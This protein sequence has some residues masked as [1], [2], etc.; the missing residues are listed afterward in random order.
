MSLDNLGEQLVLRRNKLEELKKQGVKPYGQKYPVTHTSQEIL[1][2]FTEIEGRTVKIFGRIMTKRGH[3]KAGFAHIQDSMGLIQ[4]YARQDRMGKEAYQLYQDLDIG[5]IIGLT[6][7]VFKTRTGEITINISSFELL[8]KSLRPLPE[9][10]HGLRD[11]ELRYRRR[12]LDLMVSP[13]VR[14]VFVTRSR[15][16]QHIRSFLAERGFLE[17]ET[18]V[19]HTV[20]G[21]ASARPFITHHNALGINL[22][23]RIATEL[24]LKRLIVG[25][26]DRVF[27]LGRIFR[28]EG[29]ST[30]HNP[31][32]TSVEIYQVNA[33]YED[34]MRLTEELVASAAEKILGTCKISYQN[35]ELDLSIPWPRKD[36]QQMVKEITGVDFSRISTDE[37][38][39]KVAKEHGLEFKKGTTKGEILFAFFEE[40]CEDKLTG[41]IFIK[42]YPVEVSPL[43]QRS[44][45]DPRFTYRFETFIAGKEIANAFTELI[46]PL[47]QRQRFEDQVKKRVAGDEEAH[48]MDEDFLLALEYGMP[49]TGGLGIGIDRL[50]MILTDS[51]SIRD[52]ILFPTMRPIEKE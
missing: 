4:I 15:I 21:G 36:L 32:F 46:D 47:D 27:E 51:P 19:M 37:E 7:E 24:H 12:Y 29:I 5:D 13:K 10:W 2:G 35:Q 40:F 16:I 30:N 9:K 34:M 6:G 49:P 1:Q 52:V 26:M 22:Y 3:G 41:P 31:E 33:D 8:A 23:L 42:N 18:P 48:M 11:V 50:I 45:E 14:N 39:H 25:G 43:A 28:N 38:A 17:V 44:W 20:A